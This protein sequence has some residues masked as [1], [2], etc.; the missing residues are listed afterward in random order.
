ME[1]VRKPHTDTMR[2]IITTPA[3]RLHHFLFQALGVCCEEI[4][5]KSKFEGGLSSELQ[6]LVL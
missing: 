6:R 3:V 1:G 5:S 4:T 2:F